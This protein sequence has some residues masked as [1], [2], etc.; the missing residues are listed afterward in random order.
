MYAPPEQY[1]S[2]DASRYTPRFDVWSLGVTLHKILTGEY[3]WP[4]E[5]I[6]D[7]PGIIRYITKVLPTESLTLKSK[8]LDHHTRALILAILVEVNKRPSVED[9]RQNP[10]FK[11]EY[12]QDE[13]GNRSSRERVVNKLLRLRDGNTCT[14][15]TLQVAD[16]V[17]TDT[18][19]AV[20]DPHGAIL[21]RRQVT[22]MRRATGA[23]PVRRPTESTFGMYETPMSMF[24]SQHAQ[25]RPPTMEANTDTTKTNAPRPERSTIP[26][27]GKSHW[28]WATRE[29]HFKSIGQSMSPASLRRQISEEARK[30]KDKSRR[31][32]I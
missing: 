10:F 21:G 5:H 2:K 24:Q 6:T 32:S 18:L 16:S 25:T 1:T 31:S 15:T 4:Q 3:P 23:E 30:N 8:L 9:V 29:T 11:V 26:E 13:V 17:G 27:E 20:G 12:T 7:G 22:P 14:I 28:T 19:L